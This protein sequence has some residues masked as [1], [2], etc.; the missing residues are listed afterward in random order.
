MPTLIACLSTG[1]GT[2]TE[3]VALIN[4]QP[5]SRIFLVTDEF[6][7]EKFTP[8]S[9]TELIVI[10]SSREV[11]VMKEQIRK[12]LEGRIPELEVALNMVSGSGREHMALLEAVIE[13]GLN[14]RLVTANQGRIESMGMER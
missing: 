13:L 3:V 5:W 1:K 7:R 4:S 14:F 10:D 9:R 11:L 6:G 12:A 8:D 2:W